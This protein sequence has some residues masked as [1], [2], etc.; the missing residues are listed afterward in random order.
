VDVKR[1]WRIRPI[2][3]ESRPTALTVRDRITCGLARGVKRIRCPIAPKPTSLIATASTADCNCVNDWFADS[4]KAWTHGPGGRWRVA[5]DVV[6]RW[7]NLALHLCAWAW[8]V[9][10]VLAMLGMLWMLWRAIG[11]DVTWRGWH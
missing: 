2:G 5:G 9:S 1:L 4:A 3:W 10:P 7:A 8:A 6:M 11:V